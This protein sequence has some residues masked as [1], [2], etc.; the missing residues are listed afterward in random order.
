LVW[1]RFVL[2]TFWIASDFK[3]FRKSV[4]D[5][6]YYLHIANKTLVNIIPTIC[7]FD[8]GVP[9][10][11]HFKECI[12]NSSLDKKDVLSVAKIDLNFGYE[13]KMSSTCPGS[14]SRSQLH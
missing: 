1:G 4:V 5:S 12:D 8:T 11:L 3:Y 7:C 14:L 10:L 6:A 9:C 13:V 2:G